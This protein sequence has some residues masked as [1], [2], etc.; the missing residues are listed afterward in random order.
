[1][2]LLMEQGPG[3]RIPGWDGVRGS[4][5]LWWTIVISSCGMQH[6]PL[7][8]SSEPVLVVHYFNRIN[9]KVSSK[10]Q[11]IGVCADKHY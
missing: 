7:F 11:V 5:V 8:R 6:C 1:M 3:E 2:P 4:P 10:E 9:L